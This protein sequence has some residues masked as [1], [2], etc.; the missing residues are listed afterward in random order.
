MTDKKLLE[1]YA[2]LI[3]KI[4][5]NI[6]KGQL[7]VVTSPVENYKVVEKIAEVAYKEGAR[8]VIPNWIDEKISRLTF[9]NAPDDLFDEVYEWKKLFYVDTVKKDAAYIRLAGSDPNNLK[10]VDQNRIVRMSKSMNAAVTEYR[11]R[12]MSNKNVWCVASAPTEAWAVNVF[13]DDSTEE[14]VNKLWDAIFK[15]NKI[16]EDNPVVE[17]EKHKANLLKRVQYLN[18]NKFKKLIYKNSLGTDLVIE[19]PEK[20][21]WAGGEEISE[22]GIKFMANIPTEEVFT[23]P[24]KDGVNGI[25]Y[26]SKPF[27]YNGV[28][29]DEFKVEFKDGKVIKYSAEKGQEALKSLVELDDGSSYLGEVALVPFKSVI[30]EMN[31]LFYNTLFDENASCHLAFGEAYPMSIEDGGEMTREELTKEGVNNSIAHEDFMIGTE[32][33]SIIGINKDGEKIKIFDNGNFTF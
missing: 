23:L 32:D 25:V 5:V 29:I 28:I 17:W 26:G 18:K 11:E 31:I 12:L 15:I 24:K 14:A 13:P 8:E 6:Q 2:E 9:L 33:L 7:L 16:Y 10:G 4:G 22:S 21:V 1:K 27:V 19:L 3:V 20:H 30:S